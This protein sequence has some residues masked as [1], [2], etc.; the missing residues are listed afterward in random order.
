MIRVIQL[1]T[2]ITIV[3]EITDTED[4]LKVRL[5]LRLYTTPSEDPSAPS[6]NRVEPFGM[7][8]KNQ[9]IT[10]KKEHILYME[11][12]S[13][14]LEEYYTKNILDS[15]PN[16]ERETVNSASN[17]ELSDEQITRLQAG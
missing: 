15:V 12:P 14:L 1:I 9:T 17:F 5:P 3:G 8:V 11:E 16:F 7:H 4:K 2:G 6:Q 10:I 13:A